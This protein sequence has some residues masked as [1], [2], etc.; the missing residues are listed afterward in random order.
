MVGFLKGNEAGKYRDATRY[1]RLGQ[2][3]RSAGPRNVQSPNPA[4][5]G[6]VE[7]PTPVRGTTLDHLTSDHHQCSPAG[8]RSRHLP[9]RRAA[10]S[11]MRRDVQVKFA[12]SD[13]AP[14]IRLRTGRPPDAE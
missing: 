13:Y 10:E 8:Q 9:L 4:R 2:V 11:Q 3:Y 14:G 7:L 12:S 6:G 1:R 5:A